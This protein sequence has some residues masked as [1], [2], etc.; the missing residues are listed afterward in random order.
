MNKSSSN[1]YAHEL[2]VDALTG[3]KTR[4]VFD[5]ALHAFYQNFQQGKAFSL[6]VVDIDYLK[7]VNDS[8][9]HARGDQIIKAAAECITP[10]LQASEVL[11]R[12]G[13]DE[14]VVFLA[15]SH[16]ASQHFL[17]HFLQH[18]NALVLTGN[19]PLQLSLSIGLAS[20]SEVM[21]R[22]D[23]APGA[24]TVPEAL[25]ELADFRALRAKRTGRNR[26][27]ATGDAREDIEHSF[28]D[29]LRLIERD[30]VLAEAKEFFQHLATYKRGTL[31]I[32]GPAGAGHSRLIS[33]LVTLAKLQHFNVLRISTTPA[34]KYRAFA[35]LDQSLQVAADQ[36]VIS[37]GAMRQQA[38]QTALDITGST[39]ED[40]LGLGLGQRANTA[41]KPSA[42]PKQG[43]IV[44][45][46]RLDNLDAD[47]ITLL[48]QVLRV[49][50][51]DKADAYA[52][53][54][55]DIP[56]VGVIYS[57][58]Q[59][60]RGLRLEHPLNIDLNLEP[61]SL[62]GSHMLLQSLLHKAIPE[63]LGT[64]FVKHSQGLPKHIVD[65]LYVLESE[66]ILH[67][68]GSGWVFNDY[69]TFDLA[70][71][72]KDLYRSTLPLSHDYF[73]GR[74]SDI[75]RIKAALEQRLV[76]V[77][78][79]GGIGKSRVALQVA[80]ELGR[81]EYSEV[82][83]VPLAG[84]RSP[85]FLPLTIASALDLTIN[86]TQQDSIE[87]QLR[88]RLASGHVLL[89]LDNYE[90]L[91]PD[92]RFLSW[93][94]TECPRVNVIV[95]S[96]QRLGLVREQVVQLA[97]LD[98]P[99]TVEDTYFQ[100]Y[101]AVQLFVSKAKTFSRTTLTLADYPC[102]LAIVQALQ[103]MP[104]ALEL[105]ASWLATFSLKTIEARV[106]ANLT[107]LD[108]TQASTSSAENSLEA[109]V[110]YF[111]Q[112]LS[113]VEQ[114]VVQRLAIFKGGFDAPA[115]S[116]V[117]EA[118]PFLLQGLIDRA[119][120]R[121][122]NGRYSI[123]E[124][125][126]QFAARQLEDY[127]ERAHHA[128]AD[129]ATYYAQVYTSPKVAQQ[130]SANSTTQGDAQAD[131]T[132]FLRL[133]QDL[134]NFRE[135][136]FWLLDERDYISLARYVKLFSNLLEF[137]GQYTLATQLFEAAEQKLTDVLPDPA[138][139]AFLGELYG[140]HGWLLHN[141]GH[142]S[143]GQDVL[144]QSLA[145]LEPLGAT[146]TL[147]NS[148]CYQGYLLR[149]MAKYDDAM[150]SFQQSM[151][152]ANVLDDGRL[153]ANASKGLGFV[154]HA[155][156]E[157]EDALRYYQAA[158]DYYQASADILNALMTSNLSSYIILALGR[159]DEARDSFEAV[160]A[161][162]LEHNALN[163]RVGIQFGLG[164]TAYFQADYPRAKVHYQTSFDL[165][166]A[167]QT[168]IGMSTTSK[169][170]ADIAVKEGD[171]LRAQTLLQQS[172]HHAQA[173]GTVRSVF[174]PLG[175]YVHLWLATK[176]YEEALELTSYIHEHPSPSRNTLNDAREFVGILEGVLGQA[177]VEAALAACCQDDL[178]SYLDHTFP[179]LQ[180]LIEETQ[181]QG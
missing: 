29:E 11:V 100:S 138:R 95:T 62:Q 133:E 151:D 119:F 7:R 139:D 112:Q 120:L 40:G 126:R 172:Y 60:G 162:A 12:Y 134:N 111:W 70:A 83:Y 84:L 15:R 148:Y 43:V 122:A 156:A 13:G 64:W 164:D 160:D 41:P 5:D 34:L 174:F 48:S 66:D 44:L 85:E 89:V 68:D 78:G 116:H 65:A 103:G 163:S 61:L 1:L 92:T 21:T 38:L 94:L 179:T 2:D 79:I 45:I 90:H 87:A 71:H 109:A 168:Q 14:F 177:R 171:Y 178:L 52:A 180:T 176:H 49:Q 117:A 127:P 167:T 155:K 58:L 20:A 166:V 159:Y 142:F 128:K 75:A 33:E 149:D 101:S 4:A 88:E 69:D 73:V 123:H 42:V 3:V 132:D 158:L 35:A 102:L 8:F 154:A 80:R 6:A 136:W 23:L 91:L 74:S 106:L 82:R 9:G 130:S 114:S 36:P 26:L 146:E 107:T 140:R 55:H 104:L 153:R 27:V 173:T 99:D 54:I 165:A 145:L 28:S 63:D 118:S 125:L 141:L 110:T 32:E 72:L 67:L 152:V 57:T 113:E 175:G 115:A 81:P 30:T 24:E 147:S 97:G 124:L 18:A 10:M 144:M 143:E 86:E 50:S 121:L 47:A 181:Q 135:A 96:R 77:V 93:L 39:A 157:F 19:P 56:V 37:G 108:T 105:V 131:V 98:Y 22:S 31:R 59:A 46:D 76:T 137:R 16:R 17:Q 170:L 25:F 53:W 51:S 129:H 161:L 169:R 150:Q